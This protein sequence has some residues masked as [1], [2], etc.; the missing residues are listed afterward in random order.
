M[1]P[2]PHKMLSCLVLMVIYCSALMTAFALFISQ[3][4]RS[5]Y[6]GSLSEWNARLSSVI[7]STRESAMRILGTRTSSS[8]E[9]RDQVSQMSRLVGWETSGGDR[10]SSKKLSI[11]QSSWKWTTG[12]LRYHPHMLLQVHNQRKRWIHVTATREK[13]KT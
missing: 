11:L 8:E 10:S 12:V 9:V 5:S 6:A 2:F 1:L 4:F 13:S 7:L 3:T